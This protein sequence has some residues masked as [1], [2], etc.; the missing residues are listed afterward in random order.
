[1]ILPICLSIKIKKKEKLDKVKES[2]RVINK[3]MKKKEKESK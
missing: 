2:L 3:K 1:M